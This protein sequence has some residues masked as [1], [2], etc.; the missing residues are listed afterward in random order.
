MLKNVLFDLD[1]TLLCVHMAKFKERFFELL[2]K[3]RLIAS[4]GEQGM[5]IFLKAFR[6]IHHGTGEKTNLQLL[7][8]EIQKSAPVGEKELLSQLDDFFARDFC[9]LQSVVEEVKP[10]AGQVVELLK[11]RG[12]QL[13]LATAP[14]FP[15][16]AIVQRL[17]WAGL[18]EEDFAHITSYESA[19]YHKGD[20]GYYHELMRTCQLMPEECL[21]VGNSVKED[22]VALQA[23]IKCFFIE[24]YEIGPWQEG[25]C[26]H[27]TL[28]EFLIWADRLPTLR[29]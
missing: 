14:V 28:E 20:V 26:P 3:S 10:A 9:G 13:I 2:K 18:R 22:L 4:L 29:G 12:Y 16:R 25:I 7:C 8:E 23:G 15:R 21:M 11:N 27:G 24:G 19:C 6:A 5:D 17:T 1:G